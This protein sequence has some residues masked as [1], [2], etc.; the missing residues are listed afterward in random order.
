MTVLSQPL[1]RA[2]EQGELHNLLP[3]GSAAAAEFAAASARYRRGLTVMVCGRAGVGRDT[4]ARALRERLSV[5]AIGPGEQAAAAADADLW[6]MLLAGMPRRTDHALL[7]AL[8]ADR[9][10]VVLGK[11]DTFGEPQVAA[12]MAAQA[13][14]A[15]GRSVLPVSPL[16]AC[17][18]VSADELQLLRELVAAGAQMPS[19]SAYFLAGCP[20]GS[21]ER[22][23]RVGLL[24]RVDA[25]GLDI[26]MALIRDGHPA[27]A[28]PQSL[29][30]A[31]RGYSGI[32]GVGA[33]IAG[34]VE[35][36]RYWRGVELRG[37]LERAAA[38]GHDRDAIEELLGAGGG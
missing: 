37:A 38:A 19:M 8:P 15:L 10:I 3:P 14:A 9:T 30:D 1:A 31:L 20:P 6:I 23:L 36:V 33:A 16:L 35:R 29:A 32:D 28:D 22:R 18:A 26:A 34:L 13:G 25:Y 7:S 27:A 17:A 11:A 2:A 5:T 24:R 21:D 12:E 4:L